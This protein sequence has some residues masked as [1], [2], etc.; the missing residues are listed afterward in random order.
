[1]KIWHKQRQKKMEDI[2]LVIGT[3]AFGKI[4]GV[5]NVAIKR[6]F[7]ST[8]FRGGIASVR[9][10]DIMT[11]M[12][13]SDH[14]L[15]LIEAKYNNPFSVPL[16]PA[17]GSHIQY[18]DPL[19]FCMERGTTD[20]GCLIPSKSF[21]IKDRKLFLLYLALAIEYVH[22]RGLIH[23]DIK[24]HNIIGFMSKDSELQSAKL[25]DFGHSI[26]HSIQ[27]KSDPDVV[28]LEYRA[29]EIATIQQYSYKV[30]VWAFGVVAYEAIKKTSLFNFEY[31]RSDSVLVRKISKLFE[32][33]TLCKDFASRTKVQLQIPQN[34]PNVKTIL[35][36]PFSEILRFNKV[37]GGTFD[38][39]L[40]L[41]AKT[42]KV[43]P[44]KRLSS[45][46][47][48]NHPFFSSYKNL[49]GLSRLK[50]GINK[51]GMWTTKPRQ[52]TI[53]SDKYYQERTICIG[54]I[55]SIFD[56][57]MKRSKRCFSNVCLF[58][59]LDMTDRYF[60]K[61]NTL[62]HRPNPSL[63]GFIFLVISA[64]YFT[65]YVDELNVKRIYQEYSRNWIMSEINKAEKHIIIDIFEGNIIRESYTEL[66]NN[67]HPYT[68]VELSLL[69]DY[70][71]K[72][73]PGKYFL[74]EVI[75][76]IRK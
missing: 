51:Y 46:D 47:V 2:K 28:T 38:E 22:S 17:V 26:L 31:D 19:F 18:S 59:A 21:T 64:K 67:A 60:V 12:K 20:I 27:R 1:M 70:I 9:E 40:D 15:C 4:Y 10:Y 66:I 57:D 62:K 48:V 11:K 35:N 13:D 68:E 29:P 54:E 5:G 58:H 36:L 74:N 56:L 25:S 14:C 55:L 52:I 49:I 63:Y 39:F 71:T 33:D 44:I 3:G 34:L 32:L 50:S 6:N 7:Y 53:V 42:L 73:R 16:S 65:L 61:I 30:D 8:N 76:K 23:N 69:R 75:S 72:M 45:T 37:P 43:P 24:P 41:L